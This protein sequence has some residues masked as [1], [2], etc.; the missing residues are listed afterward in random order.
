MDFDP[1]TVGSLYAADYDARHN[2][3]TTEQSV[4]LISELAG[5][6][7]RMLELAIG[8][9]RMAQL[10]GL[11]RTERW[12]GWGKDPFGPDS[13]MHVTIYRRPQ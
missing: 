11:E 9:G 6:E 8:T 4:A 2:P 3:D 5:P 12:G 10:A 1:G 7:A 13:G